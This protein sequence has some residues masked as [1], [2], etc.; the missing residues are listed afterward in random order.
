MDL[1]ESERHTDLRKRGH[2]PFEKLG[3]LSFYHFTTG[4]RQ[5]LPYNRL[6]IVRLCIGSDAQ[7]MPHPPEAT[8]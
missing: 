3:D 2:G 5:S 8:S 4:L 1:D 6:C 7:Q